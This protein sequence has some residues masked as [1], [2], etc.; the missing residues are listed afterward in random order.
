MSITYKLC[1]VASE[2]RSLVKPRI[3][4][5]DTRFESLIG[6]SAHLNIRYRQCESLDGGYYR[7]R[8]SW[9]DVYSHMAQSH[10]GPSRTGTRKDSH[11]KACSCSEGWQSGLSRRS[12]KPEVRKD[13]GVR[14]PL[15]PHNTFNNIVRALPERQ[16]TILLLIVDLNIRYLTIHKDVGLKAA[17]V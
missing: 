3:L 10:G 11:G 9:V 4:P 17:I 2:S 1:V 13:P 8:S 5:G 16:H 14:I 6:D 12:W 7:E 15:L